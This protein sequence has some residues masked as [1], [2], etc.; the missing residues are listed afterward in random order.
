M[1]KNPTWRGN[2]SHVIDRALNVNEQEVLADWFFF[3]SV[4]GW[5]SNFCF[6]SF[7][8]KYIDFNN[9][10]C[11]C[12]CC[13]CLYIKNSWTCSG[14]RPW[15]TKALTLIWVYMGRSYL[16]MLYR[17]SCAALHRQKNEKPI[18]RW[19]LTEWSV[20]SCPLHVSIQ[21]V[22]R[23]TLKAVLQWC[24]SILCSILQ[25]LPTATWQL[26]PSN[27]AKH[28]VTTNRAHPVGPGPLGSIN[29]KKGLT[30]LREPRGTKQTYTLTQARS[31]R[32]YSQ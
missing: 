11:C 21:Y 22:G 20:D 28:W 19:L 3:A 24:L 6:A 30:G 4:L 2:K 32:L 31:E 13:F 18:R 14:V 1:K 5:L 25:P 15:G 17:L 8:L 7:Q 27:H 23:Q 29:R 12:C 10:T 26:W 9:E 16:N